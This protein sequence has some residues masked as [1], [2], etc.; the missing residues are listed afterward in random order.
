MKQEDLENNVDTTTRK[1][2]GMRRSK[3]GVGHPPPGEEGI[4]RA[5]T[6]AIEKTG[7]PKAQVHNL[8]QGEL[9]KNA[10]RSEKGSADEAL[11]YFVNIGF[12]S[13]ENNIVRLL[14]PPEDRPRR[15]VPDL[16]PLGPLLPIPLPTSTTTA[17]PT[18]TLEVTM[19][20]KKT[21]SDILSYPCRRFRSGNLEFYEMTVPA[22]TLAK[23][24][25]VTRHEENAD[26]VQRG[27]RLPH[28]KKIAS[29][30]RSGT[31]FPENMLVNLEGNWS[32]DD[33]MVIGDPKDKKA[34]AVFDILDGQHR[35]EAILALVGSGEHE[36]V[37]RYEFKIIAVIGANTDQC[38]DL[39]RLQTERM[40]VDRSHLLELAAEDGRFATNGTA[41]AYKL[42][43]ILNEHPA[44]PLKGRVMFGEK[45]GSRGWSRIKEGEFHISSLIVQLRV[46]G[47][48]RKGLMRSYSV[49]RRGEMLIDLFR[50]ANAVYG[51][52]L[53]PD[54]PL[55]RASGICALIAL[56][57][58]EGHF[59]L[60][61]ARSGAGND[62]YTYDN[63]RSAFE[64][65][66][67]FMWK[68]RA[69]S[70][71]AKQMQP[72][73]VAKRFNEFLKNRDA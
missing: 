30:M 27:L 46:L 37:E 64:K 73:A 5:L 16:K 36:I 6:R 70:P 28:V 14:N 7:L 26:G 18:P 29:A 24:G 48:D 42:A 23:F 66:A 33:E 20:A 31:A 19:T 12:I 17:Q 56:L 68:L 25:R 11:R 8:I 69:N 47:A 57:A 9:R 60:V 35:H 72:Y 39:F 1:T 21:D 40:P 15:T 41:N 61:L 2:Q 50:A 54:H 53:D 34:P 10:S 49:E 52:F 62:P 59:H 22:A 4:K 44:S 45:Q 63:M 13:S 55:G 3:F 71:E 51:R 38:R 65:N 43:K 32:A 58:V 67:R